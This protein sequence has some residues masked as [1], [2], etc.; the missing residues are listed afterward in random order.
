MRRWL[1]WLL[2][3]VLLVIAA[4]VIALPGPRYT[5]W[6]QIRGESYFEGW[7]TSYWRDVLRN[8]SKPRQASILDPL[9]RLLGTTWPPAPTWESILLGGDPKS[10][11]VL[12]E[13]LHDDD[14]FVRAIAC[15][16]LG[17]IAHR[18]RDSQQT[19]VGLEAAIPEIMQ[20]LTGA[21]ESGIDKSSAVIALGSFGPDARDA[22]PLLLRGLK[23]D[24]PRIR[25]RNA[26]ALCMIDLRHDDARSVLV[27]GL[28]DA[29]HITR[30]NAIE[31]LWLA[32][33]VHGEKGVAILQEREP[34]LPAVLRDALKQESDK[35]NPARIRQILEQLQ[36]A[37]PRDDTQLQ[38]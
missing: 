24:H 9:H 11:G 6:G 22:M 5:L 23:S 33:G 8:A 14:D 4:V 30:H 26:R 25:M 32:L 10:L 2:P 27:A 36:P 18:A 19:V 38:P 20:V 13:L 7:P 28:A 15:N 16:G 35:D 17:N 12:R 3:P 1:L 34:H 37:S 29:D 31:G 21:S